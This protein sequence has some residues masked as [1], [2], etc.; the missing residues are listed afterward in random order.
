MKMCVMCGR[1]HKRLVD[2]IRSLIVLFIFL[3]LISLHFSVHSYSTWV[4][5]SRLMQYFL[6]HYEGFTYLLTLCL[7]MHVKSVF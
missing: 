5:S 6:L 2:E 4:G 7:C 3:A 1:Q